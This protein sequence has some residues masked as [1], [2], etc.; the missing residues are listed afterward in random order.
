MG[1]GTTLVGPS[2]DKAGP[3][4][5]ELPEVET[6][7]LAGPDVIEVSAAGFPIGSSS[8]DESSICKSFLNARDGLVKAF[9]RMENHSDNNFFPIEAKTQ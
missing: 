3:G 5:C 4:K 1:S 2:P 7:T 8:S 6:A 9:Q